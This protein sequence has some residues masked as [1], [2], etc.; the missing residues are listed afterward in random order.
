[1]IRADPGLEPRLTLKVTPPRVPK[2]LIDRAAVSLE[3]AR[4]RD[5]PVVAIEAPGGFGK[6]SLLGEWRRAWLLRGAVVAWLSADEGDSPSRFARAIALSMERASGREGFARIR[7]RETSSAQELDRLTEWLSEVADLASEAVLIIDEADRLPARTLEGSVEY[8]LANAPANLRVALASRRHLPLGLAGLIAHGAPARVSEED[9]RLSLPQTVALLH[10]RFGGEIDS[11]AAAGIHEL[12]RGW[13]LG[14]ELASESLARASTHRAPRR[15]PGARNGRRRTDLEHYLLETLLADRPPHEREFLA[16]ISIVE[17]LN[18]EL[19]KALTRRADAARVLARLRETTPLLAESL[20]AG[21][22]TMHPMAREVLREEFERLPAATR[23]RVHAAAAAWLEAHHLEEEAARH[24]LESGQRERAWALAD[25]FLF[26][27]LA[28]GEVGRVRDWLERAPLP[29]R[30]PSPQRL[31]AAGWSY[32]LGARYDEARRLARRVLRD[33]RSSRGER[34]IATLMLS[35]A[36]IYVD[37]IDRAERLVQR[38][39]GRMRREGPGIFDGGCQ[40]AMIALHR[41]C[42]A[43]ARRILRRARPLEKGSELELV[44]AFG[45]VIEG[46]SYLWEGDAARASAVLKAALAASERTAGRRGMTALTLAGPCAL[47][48]SECGETGEAA[49]VLLGRLDAIEQLATPSGLLAGFV[50]ASRIALSRGDERRACELL[51]EVRAIGESRRMPRVQVIATTELI[52]MHAARGRAETCKTLLDRIDAVLAPAHDLAGRFKDLLRLQ[53]SIAAAHA[54][55]AAADRPAALGA[56]SRAARLA[57]S[58]RRGRDGIEIK[59]LRAAWMHARGED[60]RSLVAEATG[61]ARSLGLRRLLA[62]PPV[63]LPHGAAVR[64]AERSGATLQLSKSS[65]TPESVAEQAASG[66]STRARS[67]SAPIGRVAPTALLT[68]KEREV[69]RLLAQ[70]LSNK[71]IATALDVGRT[72]VKWHLKNVFSKLNAASR[73]HAVQRARM[74]EILAP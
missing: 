47:A 62:E 29:K 57:E 4:L 11:D 51:E 61:L 14:V 30:A 26:R 37:R 58:L 10:A 45:A 13:P 55:H 46:L 66:G 73:E 19:C 41:G 15:A 54:A 64:G 52:R 36:E 65:A 42:P 39:K 2:R 63:D 9:L 49:T 50:A 56:L 20:D 16:R 27:A 71:Q 23:K 48:L 7:H 5:A 25:R 6:T 28:Q 12:T 31:L 53:R 24:A 59:L 17:R 60:P 18:P 38:W 68:P 69:L 40:L 1:M 8:I 33:R 72:T 21:W 67:R 32:A 3:S 34:A 70:R 74:L 35:A 43:E 22:S 44:E